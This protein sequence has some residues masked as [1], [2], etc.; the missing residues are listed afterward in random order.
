MVESCVAE[1]APAVA[2][3]VAAPEGERKPF[4]YLPPYTTAQLL[5]ISER[6]TARY[7]Q[8]DR[9]DAAQEFLVGALRA[10][11]RARPGTLTRCYQWHCGMGFVKNFLTRKTRRRAR[12][13]VSLDAP[14]GDGTSGMTLGNCVRDP[15][16]VDPAACVEA[17]DLRHRLRARVD[18][19]LDKRIRHIIRERFWRGRQMEAIAADLG[20]TPERAGQL[21]AQGLGVLR[22]YVS[23]LGLIRG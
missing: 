13:R 10:A 11:K 4:G 6:V 16:A 21:L 23:R 12:V 20:I 9:E 2:V 14:V 17:A 1:I 5:E 7:D 19:L 18:A 3:V 8:N 22:A 15:K